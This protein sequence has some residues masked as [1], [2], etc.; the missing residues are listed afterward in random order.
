M[1]S[2]RIHPLVASTSVK[3]FLQSFE[4]LGYMSRKQEYEFEILDKEVLRSSNLVLTSESENPTHF[5]FTYF[6]LEIKFGKSYLFTNREMVKISWKP[7]YSSP[8]SNGLTKDSLMLLY[9][10]VRKLVVNNYSRHIGHKV[11]TK[12]VSRKADVNV[13]LSKLVRPEL[14][15]SARR[16]KS[17]CSAEVGSGTKLGRRDCHLEARAGLMFGGCLNH[18]IEHICHKCKFVLVSNPY[19]EKILLSFLQRVQ[20]LPS[21][22]R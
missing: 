19:G 12:D 7:P 8:L 14:F 3:G 1:R 18:Q 10:Y 16:S 17:A 9:Q 5:E 4:D 6:V 2:L 13:R 20:L 22:H 15:S 21:G 11:T